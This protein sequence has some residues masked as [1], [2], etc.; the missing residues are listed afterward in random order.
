M[1]YIWTTLHVFHIN[2]FWIDLRHWENNIPEP[3]FFF[4]FFKAFAATSSTS[5]Q[6]YLQV[7]SEI[8]SNN[9]AKYYFSII[10]YFFKEKSRK[11]ELKNFI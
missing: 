7:D 4:S 6:L 11:I 2:F 1:S 10:I 5:F 9:K 3:S 8:K